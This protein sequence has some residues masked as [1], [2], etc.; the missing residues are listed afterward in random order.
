MLLSLALS[1]LADDVAAIDAAFDLVLRRKAIGAEVLAQQRD[2][3]LGGRY[4]ALR[5]QLNQLTAVRSQIAQWTLSGPVAVGADAYRLMLAEA[6]ELQERLEAELAHQIPEM[7]LTSRLRSADRRTIT[8]TLPPDAALVEFARFV[9]FEF[10]GLAAEFRSVIE[11][12]HYAAFV[13]AGGEPDHVQIVDLGATSRIDGL[14]AEFRESITGDAEGRGERHA[15]PRGA[16][17]TSSTSDDAGRQLRAAVFDPLTALLGGRRRLVIA[18]D[19]ELTRLPFEVLPSEDAT[20][21]IDAYQISYL[22]VGRDI[23]AMDSVSQLNQAIV[24]ADPDFDLADRMADE[25][26]GG[27]ADSQSLDARDADRL[28]FGRLPGTRVEGEQVAALLGVEPL[29]DRRALEGRLKTCQTPA[30][31]HIATH[32]F[33]L[34]NR[35]AG[36][37]Q[38]QP[39]ASMIGAS[40][41]A[42]AAVEA[43]APYPLLR[44][45]LALAGANARETGH[46]LPAE[47]EDGIL[48]AEDVSGL[49]LFGTELVVLSACETGLGEVQVGEGVLGLQRA[50][51]LAGA[52]TLIMSLWKVPDEQTQELMVD[53]Y[54]RLLNGDGRLDAL[55]GAQLSLRSKYPQPYYWGAFVCRGETRS[56]PS[57]LERAA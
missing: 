28:H 44:S 25:S 30:I 7:D 51:V 54:R 37:S 52:R 55:R 11:G 40:G 24:V 6:S 34:E 57:S 17:P 53:F 10:G 47:A 12:P 46:A 14:I 26:G 35:K 27:I 36:S 5:E 39:V 22:S 45:G 15:R 9:W 20:R 18:P 16:V 23:V 29:L 50:F 13:L 38:R 19:G 42:S 33:F 49:N 31:L 41:T 32:G 3:V 21:L 1:Y 48:T 2:T 4:P 56:L 8:G 43:T